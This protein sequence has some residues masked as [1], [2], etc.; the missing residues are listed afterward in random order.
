MLNPYG[1]DQV[2]S[3]MHHMSRFLDCFFKMSLKHGV[4]NAWPAKFSAES[5][6]PQ[7]KEKNKIR[8]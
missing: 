2:N 4:A 5:P 7:K 6:P 3:L 8:S 1:F